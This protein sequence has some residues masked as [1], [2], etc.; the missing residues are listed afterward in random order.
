MAVHTGKLLDAGAMDDMP[1]DLLIGIMKAKSGV[2]NDGKRTASLP[3]REDG[4][5]KKRKTNSLRE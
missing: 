3:E 1:A 5:K 4:K 2:S